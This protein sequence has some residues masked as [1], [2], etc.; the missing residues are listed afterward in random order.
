MTCCRISVVFPKTGAAPPFS[1]RE[2][3]LAAA[4]LG[5]FPTDSAID[6]LEL[7]FLHVVQR[8]AR[9]GA[10]SPQGELSFV[11]SN[12]MGARSLPAYI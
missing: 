12:L 8:R 4:A 7:Q 5:A 9:S 6:G 10:S 3:A 11:K 2:F 1:A